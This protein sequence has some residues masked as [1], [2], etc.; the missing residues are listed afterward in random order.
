MIYPRIMFPDRSVCKG[1]ATQGESRKRSDTGLDHDGMPFWSK[2][3]KRFIRAPHV[4]PHEEARH[5]GAQKIQVIKVEAIVY[6]EPDLSTAILLV[7][8]ESKGREEIKWFKYEQ[9]EGVCGAD[10]AVE[11]FGPIWR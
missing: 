9:L 1:P 4:S 8:F 11:R 6:S 3:S 5:D 7:I 10:E 2:I